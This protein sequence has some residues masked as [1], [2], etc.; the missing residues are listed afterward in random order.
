MP[1]MTKPEDWHAKGQ[2]WMIDKLKEGL[3]PA[4]IESLQRDGMWWEIFTLFAEL[5]HCPENIAFLD[6][7][8]AFKQ[9]NN[10][11]MAVD[12][13]DEYVKEAAPNQVNLPYTMVTP[14]KAILEDADDPATPEM[15]DKAYDEI[16]RIT[17]SGTFPNFAAACAAARPGLLAEDEPE[18]EANEEEDEAPAAQVIGDVKLREMTRDKIDMAVVDNF[19]KVAITDLPLGGSTGC[20]QVGDLVIIEAGM[21]DD[22]PYMKW[23]RAQAGVTRGANITKTAKAGAFSSGTITAKGAG[24]KELFKKAIARVSKAKVVFE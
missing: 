12:I 21:G 10:M 20:Y 6:Q 4:D 11:N 9:T 2:P 8:M 24:D 17:R 18:E 1:I 19:N 23:I 14:L 15:F 16:L 5:E 22:Q 13:Y 3:P 7:V